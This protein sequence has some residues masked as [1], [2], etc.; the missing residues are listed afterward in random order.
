MLLNVA[1]VRAVQFLNALASIEKVQF[2][3]SISFSPEF[4]KEDAPKLLNFEQFLR[5]L[6][7]CTPEFSNALCANETKVDAGSEIDV[8]PAVSLSALTPI[9]VTFVV[10]SVS[11]FRSVEQ[12]INA[13]VL[14]SVN[15]LAS[16]KV[17]RLEQF[18]NV[19]AS[20]ILTAVFSKPETAV[21]LEQPS[22]ADS[23]SVDNA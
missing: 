18:A 5:L 9:F 12:P 2:G 14:I 17:E 10:E 7:F 4:M 20:R 11:R 13:S 21:R 15:P 22:N 23:P 1:F 6:I 19:L 8:S 3:N 16:D